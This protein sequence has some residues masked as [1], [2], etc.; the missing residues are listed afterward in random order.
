MNTLISE[1]QTVK[2]Q[3]KL[4][5]TILTEAPSQILA[6]QFIMTL[7]KKQQSEAVVVPVTESGQQILLG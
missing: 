1:E 3:V 4:N 5:G 6:E 2:Y 7:A